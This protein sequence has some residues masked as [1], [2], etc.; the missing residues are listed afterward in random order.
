MSDALFEG[1]L[2]KM[3]R[4]REGGVNPFPARVPDTEAVSFVIE[5]HENLA[6]EEH[7]GEKVSV[8]GRLTAFR[9]MGKAAFLDVRDGTARIQ[10]H[11]TM[12]RL[13]E[14]SFA[15]LREADIGDHLAF[16][17]EVFRTKRGELTIAAETWTHLSKSLR[18]LPEKWHGLKDAETRHRHRSLDLISNDEVRRT[19]TQRSRLIASIRS[20]LNRHGFLEVE[21]PTLQPIPGGAAARPFTTHHNALDADLYMRV[22]LE[23]Y[24]KRILI[25]GF[26]RVYE[27]GKCFRNEGVSTEHN[28]EFTMLEIYQA[29]TDVEGIMAQTEALIVEALQETIGTLAIDFA[30]H[31]IDFTP[32]WPRISMRSAV[33]QATGIDLD[34]TADE[35]RARADAVDIPLPSGSWGVLVAELFERAVESTLIQPTFI[36]DYP[37]EIS[38]LAKKNPADERFVERFEL[39]IAG[40]EVSNGFT[41]LNDPIDQRSRFEA[42]EALR[43][44]GDE[45][46]HRIDEDFLF[47]LEHGMPPTGGVGIGIDRLVMLATGSTSIRDVIFFPTLRRKDD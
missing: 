23:L 39:F 33:E 26:D 41:E 31:A 47:A 5:R 16:F 10:I 44:S 18:P 21:T 12:D 9:K 40:M 3:T 13:G 24:L 2:E 38:P 19:F 46:A 35:V 17:G 7:S 15:A 6:A 22:A 25:G 4:L 28:P 27:I 32:P 34:G 45:E 36:T 14:A 11:A 30:E 43:A 8:A 1:R 42:Q 29:Y 20:F 37:V